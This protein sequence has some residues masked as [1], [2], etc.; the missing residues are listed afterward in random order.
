MVTCIALLRGIN[1]NPKK[2]IA[3]ADLRALVAELGYGNVRTLVNSGNVVFDV[4]EPRANGEIA[5]SIEAAI[6]ERTGLTVPV[7]VRTGEEMREIVSRN[8]FPELAAT[9]KLLHVSF[10]A[11]E[12]APD[13]VAA[14]QEIERGEDDF[15]VIGSEVYLS[16]PNGLS[17][18][19]LDFSRLDKALRVTAT[20]RNWNTVTKLAQMAN[21]G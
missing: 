4:E 2:R 5:E 1:V 16:V 3:M 9:P 20:S 14:M 8:P 17:G 19:T 18:A 12:P 21:E 10:L 6:L 7:V 15:R 13:H 11:T